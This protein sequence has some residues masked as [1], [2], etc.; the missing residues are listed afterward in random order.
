MVNVTHVDFLC[1]EERGRTFQFSNLFID[2]RK[3]K[4]KEIKSKKPSKRC[5]QSSFKPHFNMFI[6]AIDQ[7]KNKIGLKLLF[8][9]NLGLR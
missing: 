6:H 5:A 9:K 1:S 7:N 2:L 4:K 3:E 8:L